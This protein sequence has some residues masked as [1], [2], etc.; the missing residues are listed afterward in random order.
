MYNDRSC[1]TEKFKL[2]LCYHS[3]LKWCLCAYVIVHTI[4]PP[5]LVF[6][7]IELGGK[8]KWRPLNFG[9]DDVV[10]HP[11]CKAPKIFKIAVT[12]SNF[13]LVGFSYFDSRRNYKFHSC[14]VH[15]YCV[16]LFCFFF[17]RGNIFTVD[18]GRIFLQPWPSPVSKGHRVS[19]VLF[20]FVLVVDLSCQSHS[21]SCHIMTTKA[22]RVVWYGYCVAKYPGYAWFANL[23]ADRRGP[24][25]M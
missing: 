24:R 15:S 16:D 20:L 4:L 3:L 10:S 14:G 17:R 7:W 8:P 11:A 6:L 12:S 19:F 25:W 1:Q 23:P 21:L 18:C 13:F 9:C 22:T 5:S 2:L